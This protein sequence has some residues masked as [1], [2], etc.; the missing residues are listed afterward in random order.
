LQWD[1]IGVIVAGD[2]VFGSGSSQLQS[3]WGVYVDSNNTIYVADYSNHR[4]QQWFPNAVSGNTVIGVTGVSGSNG[5]LLNY[6]IAVYGDTQ[7]RLYVGDSNGIRVWSLGASVGYPLPGSSGIGPINGIFVDK[8]GN[9]YASALSSCAV[10]M[11]T[12]TGTASTLVAGGTGCGPSSSQLYDPYGLSVDSSTSTIFIS[13]WNVQTIVSWPIG[14]TN[15]TIIAGQNSI[16][17]TDAFL[18]KYPC[19]V[20]LDPYGNL[21]VADSGNNRI[22]LFCQNPSSTSATII[23][24]YQLSYPQS[25][26]LDS[27]LNLYVSSA[28]NS[29]VQKF[30]RIV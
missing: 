1:E 27:N 4:I 30:T 12:P 5:S 13:N 10:R 29:Q 2:G 17:G 9:I 18:L 24:G 23:A 8:N 6:P 16:S 19:D 3:P 14:A 7:Q 26:A 21:Y 28:G 15:G 25:I 11:W 20:K 22:L